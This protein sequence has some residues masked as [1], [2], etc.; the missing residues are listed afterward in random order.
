MCF[1]NQSSLS[2]PSPN[3]IPSFL[4]IVAGSDDAGE[5]KHDDMDVAG[6]P[7][8]GSNVTGNVTE[9]DDDSSQ[10]LSIWRVM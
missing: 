8:A 2:G 10:D 6:F 7:F 3:H 5:L 4:A 9:S 1:V